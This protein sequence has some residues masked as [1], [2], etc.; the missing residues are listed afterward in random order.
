LDD[1]D[2]AQFLDRQVDLGQ[3]E[4]RDREIKIPVE[5]FQLKQVLCKQPPGS[6]STRVPAGGRG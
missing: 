2:F 1:Q 4:S 6:N 3:A 5:S